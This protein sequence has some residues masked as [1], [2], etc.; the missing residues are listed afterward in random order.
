MHLGISL[1]T[2]SGCTNSVQLASRMASSWKIPL[3]TF[4]GTGESSGDKKQFT[5]LSRLSYTMN[6]FAKFYVAVF[7]VS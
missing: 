5:T 2:I 4:G 3:M 7:N 1:M 6:T